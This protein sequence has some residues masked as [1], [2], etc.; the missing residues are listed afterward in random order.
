MAQDPVCFN[1]PLRVAQSLC[2]HC[3]KY[4][5]SACLKEGSEY[6]YCNNP[7]CVKA[8]EAEIAP[9]S[10]PLD[11][12]ASTE[13]LP[14]DLIELARYPNSIEANRVKAKLESEGLEC[15]STEMPCGRIEEP[16]IVPVQLMVKEAD[17]DKAGETLSGAQ[18]DGFPEPVETVISYIEPQDAEDAQGKLASSG[19]Q[20]FLWNYLATDERG[21]F[22]DLFSV[23]TR[24]SAV[25][26][27]T[28]LLVVPESE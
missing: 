2:H 28:N 12:P 11:P 13:A 14:K 26:K 8:L 5:C 23:L 17:L 25:K 3:G 21:R 27:A 10:P 24:A 9:P 7:E 15:F 22:H 6:Y 20:S 16:Y 18:S 19:I 1:H 4:Y